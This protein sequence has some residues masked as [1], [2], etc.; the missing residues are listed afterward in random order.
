MIKVEVPLGDR[1]YSVLV[2][3][4]AVNKLNSLIPA[5]AE[6]AFVVTQAGVGVTVDPG[7]PYQ[8]AHIPA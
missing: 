3:P 6:R 5:D 2:G 7:I 4:G 1:S 8:V